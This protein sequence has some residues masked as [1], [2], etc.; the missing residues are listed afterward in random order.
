MAAWAGEGRAGDSA[1]APAS[2]VLASYYTLAMAGTRPSLA[3]TQAHPVL[4]VPGLFAPPRAYRHWQ[5]QLQRCW[6]Q[7]VIRT[8]DI[9]AWAWWGTLRENFAP[10]LRLISRAAQ[11][12]QLATDGQPL[13]LIG[14]SAGGRLARLWLAERSY[15]GIECGGHRLTSAVVMLGAAQRTTEPWSRRS[16]TWANEHL[17]G[18]FYPH[19]RYI[20]VIGRGLSGRWPLLGTLTPVALN[21]RTQGGVAE[22]WGDGV[23]P[24]SAASLPGAINCVLDGVWHLGL[25]T[26]PGY[27][28]PHVLP[29]WAQLVF[30]SP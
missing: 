11:D 19:V 27:D 21:Y 29:Q 12:L 16:V 1:T 10:A 17:P 6:P 3:P 8:V 20:T 28:H 30:G 24:L 26:Q 4:I 2:F 23:I 5:Q 15:R 18:P 13:T 25:G 14:H 7:A 22:E 9:P